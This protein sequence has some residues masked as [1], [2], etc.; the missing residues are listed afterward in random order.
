[1][2]SKLLES[3]TMKPIFLILVCV[4][5]IIKLNDAK[6]SEYNNQFLDRNHVNQTHNK[7]HHH[8]HHHQK[9]HHDENQPHLQH[10]QAA[11]KRILHHN[12]KSFQ[13][14][15]NHLRHHINSTVANRTIIA[16]N[17]NRSQKPFLDDNSQK[18]D[19]K[20]TN[21]RLTLVNSNGRRYD[22]RR[23][24]QGARTNIHRSWSDHDPHQTTTTMS[25]RKNGRFEPEGEFDEWGIN[26]EATTQR[27]VVNHNN[28]KPI[29]GGE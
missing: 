15:H 13:N 5:F 12:H 4:L 3:L 22:D 7:S 19:N 1:M 27:P 29:N 18:T 28:N 8:T 21:L 9:P 14:R 25:T 2:S 16:H 10:N 26:A 23:N 11:S 17:I 20:N 24:N 6:L